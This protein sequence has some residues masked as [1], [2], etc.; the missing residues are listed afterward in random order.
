MILELW[1]SRR[2]DYLEEVSSELD[3]R[4]DIC[5]REFQP[6]GTVKAE[7]LAGCRYLNVF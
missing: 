3:L 5:Q 6:E 2:K 7:R 1:G 4:V